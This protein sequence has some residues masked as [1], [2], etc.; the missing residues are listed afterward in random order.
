MNPELFKEISDSTKALVAA[1]DRYQNAKLV[2][3]NKLSIRKY[4]LE[5]QYIENGS[6]YTDRN[7]I[8]HNMLNRI[9]YLLNYLWEIKNVAIVDEMVSAGKQSKL[10]DAPGFPILQLSRE[11]I[12]K[13]P[14]Q[15]EYHLE[16]SENQ[17]SLHYSGHVFST[18][19][20]ESAQCHAELEDDIDTIKFVYNSIGVSVPL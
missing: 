8:G 12:V 6:S 5:Q 10:I 4:E 15:W 17:T 14:E 1:E 18:G 3:E 16:D 19:S 11:I 2:L 20:L 9:N 13:S 7:E